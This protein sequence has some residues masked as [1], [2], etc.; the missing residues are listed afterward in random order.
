MCAE[1][2]CPGEGRLA[3]GAL[4]WTGRLGRAGTE[5]W[6]PESGEGLQPQSQ[7]VPL[8]SEGCQA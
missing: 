4:R 3:L 1:R 2:G 6:T 5:S 7:A 8:R